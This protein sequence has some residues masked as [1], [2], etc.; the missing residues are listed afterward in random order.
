MVFFRDE[1]VQVS[2]R[3]K[4]RGVE[5]SLGGIMRMQMELA[6]GGRRE[7]ERVVG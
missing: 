7:G 1:I 6:I 4:Q 2:L 3:L 5:W